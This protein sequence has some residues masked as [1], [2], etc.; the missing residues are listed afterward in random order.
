MSDNVLDRLPMLLNG[1][2]VGQG[3]SVQNGGKAH[4]KALLQGGNEVSVRAQETQQ[5]NFFT[6]GSSNERR[7]TASQQR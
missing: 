2:T 5:P 4:M 6:P 7:L 3:K 1:G